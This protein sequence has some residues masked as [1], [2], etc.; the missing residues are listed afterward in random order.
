MSGKK[1]KKAINLIGGKKRKIT[2]KKRR[3]PKRQERKS[4]GRSRGGR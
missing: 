3:Q 2:A 4:R 1:E